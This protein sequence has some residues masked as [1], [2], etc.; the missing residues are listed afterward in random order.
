MS[1]PP[2]A[3]IRPTSPRSSPPE[4]CDAASPSS[5]G[6]SAKD[7]NAPAKWM[8]TSL[9]PA[10]HCSNEKIKAL[11]LSDPLYLSFPAARIPGGIFL[12]LNE[13]TFLYFFEYYLFFKINEI[14]DFSSLLAINQ[15]YILI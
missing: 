11:S 2:T 4:I 3:A 7:E 1:K 13:I 8:N 12:S 6:P 9:A 5:F 14:I 10:L 15:L